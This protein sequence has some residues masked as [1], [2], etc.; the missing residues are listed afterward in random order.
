MQYLEE[1][2][3]HFKLLNVSIFDKIAF[4]I[5]HAFYDSLYS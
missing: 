4:C 5:G 1:K 2:I 3:A